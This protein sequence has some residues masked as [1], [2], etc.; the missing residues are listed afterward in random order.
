MNKKKLIIIL[1]IVVAIII[2]ATVLITIYIKNKSKYDFEIERVTEINYNII[3]SKDRYGVIDR[4]GNVVVE[5]IYDIVQIPNPSKDIFVCMYEYNVE[6]REYKVK[7]LN[8]KGNE[9]YPGYD[10][11]QAIPTETTYDGIPFEK[12]VLKY[13]KDGKYG[14]LN[15]NGKE[16][17]AAEYDQ[18]LAISYKEGMLL[19]KQNDK[20]GVIN[21]NG[22]IVIPIDYETITADNYYNEKTLYKTAGFIVSKKSDE[23]Y[24]YGYINYKGAMVVNTEYTEI[25]RVTEIQD[26][27]NIYLVALKGGQAGLLQNKKVLLN[28][29]YEDIS[30][31]SYN[32]VFVIQRNG[33]QGIANKDGSI[34]IQPEY[35]SILFGGIYINAQKDGQVLLLDLNGN[36]VD[37]KDILSK[38][39][40]KDGK[41]YI[42]SDKNEKYK[43]VDENGN[44]VVDNNYSYIEELENNYYIVANGNKNGIIDLSGK[45][46]VDL[47][48]NSI[49]H[50]R[51]TEL[52]QANISSTYTIS[53]IDKNV[54]KTLV[55]MD[56]AS[57]QVKENYV[58]VYSKTENRYFDFS[59][60]E[61][62]NKQVF[63]NNQLY[64]KKINDKWGFIDK[65]G[66]LKVQNEYDMVTEFN[67]YGF[68]GIKKDGKWGSVNSKGEVIQEPIYE[69]EGIIPMFIGKFYKV[70]EWYGDQYYTDNIKK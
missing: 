23:G 2:V 14:L 70:E 41:H 56:N 31:N 10:N 49:F 1:S 60:K 13:K 64:A 59:G 19:V 12:T 37:D 9:L 57:V 27:N 68:A 69:V 36:K 42:I 3:N 50:L 25:E 39:P 22:K 54:M 5:P 30:Y 33:K 62:T 61:L 65:N 7:V 17:T 66:N 46:V 20:C 45:A 21:I 44:V 53:L 51:N 18:I 40:T 55:T 29:E 43:I 4:E 34:K 58:R 24:R 48:Y 8:A 15:I 6:K 38:V 35:E 28:Y 63:P 52:L 16:I 26:D 47:K 32:E 67:E 11:I